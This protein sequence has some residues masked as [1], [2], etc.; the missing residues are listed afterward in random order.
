MR[1]SEF[2]KTAGL[3]A[4]GLLLGNFPGVPPARKERVK[5]YENYVK[6]LEYHEY[7]EV[8]D[9]LSVDTP[10]QLVREPDNYY[11]KFA[12]QVFFQE[13]LLGYIAAFENVVLA[14][15][16]DHGVELQANVSGTGLPQELIQQALTVEVHAEILL[17]EHPEPEENLLDQPAD[18]V[19]DQYRQEG[20]RAPKM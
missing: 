1:R 8:H 12:I 11:D 3:G 6:G 17:P 4:G 13:Y 10:L 7:R 15:L 19:K 16:L 9:R 5:L 2:L 18:Q 14:H 20:I